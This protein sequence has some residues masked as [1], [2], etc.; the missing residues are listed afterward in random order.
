MLQLQQNSISQQK[1][2]ARSNA[3]QFHQLL[4]ISKNIGIGNSELQSYA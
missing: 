1:N 3:E 2:S 4:K